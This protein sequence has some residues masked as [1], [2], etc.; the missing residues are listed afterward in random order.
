MKKTL[1]LIFV[2]VLL[3]STVLML[4][5]CSNISESYAKKINLA[6]ENDEHYTYTQVLEDLGDGAID[7]TIAKNG[8]IIAV[9]GCESVDEIEDLI[10]D[11]KDVKGIIVT[12]VLGK[13]ISA[14][15]T[16]ITEDD[17]K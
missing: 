8:V 10:D 14:K 16:V 11:G 15:Y 1:S 13:A 12:V 17:L 2:T 3:L 5:S 7:M 6:A 4:A 9:Q